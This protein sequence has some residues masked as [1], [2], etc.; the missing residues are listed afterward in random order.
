MRSIVYQ[1]FGHP[2]EVLKP[3]DRPR[4]DPGPGQALVR[5]LLSPHP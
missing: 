1:S 4:P 2:E 3:E 5:M